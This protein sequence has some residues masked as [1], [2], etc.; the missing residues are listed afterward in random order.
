M[1]DLAEARIPTPAPAKTHW[2]TAAPG[3]DPGAS[4]RRDG[5]QEPRRQ[6]SGAE[7]PPNNRATRKHNRSEGT[8]NP[9]RPRLLTERRQPSAPGGTGLA[10]HSSKKEAQMELPP[11]K[12][13]LHASNEEGRP[14][15]GAE[16][17]GPPRVPRRA[18]VQPVEPAGRYTQSGPVW[19][20]NRL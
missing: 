12:E 5:R 11:E 10:V 9:T 7:A 1:A 16:L 20:L 18:R 3:R 6:T 8:D 2:K 14:F 13:E 15:A 4:C 17:R 19:A